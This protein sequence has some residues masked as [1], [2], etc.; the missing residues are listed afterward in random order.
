MAFLVAGDL[1][2]RLRADLT[3][4]DEALEASEKQLDKSSKKGEGALGMLTSKWAIMA[5]VATGAAYAMI[6]A[7]PSL[8]FAM[9][10]VAYRF[11]NMLAILGEEFAPLIEEVVL[12]ALD[13][14]LPVIK[15]LA[16]VIGEAVENIV[17]F[18]KTEE[19]QEFFGRTL[20]A[21]TEVATALW[22]LLEPAFQAVWDIL[23][24]V[25]PYLAATFLVTLEWVADAL[26]G[27]VGFVEWL[28]GALHEFAI[29]MNIEYG[30][31]WMLEFFAGLLKGGV[32][33]AIN[34]VW[35][36]INWLGDKFGWIA[37]I[38]KGVIGWIEEFWEKAEPLL[39]TPEGGYIDTGFVFNPG[40]TEGFLG[41]QSGGYVERSG[42][43]IVH[44]GE[45]ITPRG[46]GAPGGGRV[47]H[48]TINMGSPQI[49]SDYDVRRM[50]ETMS[51]ELQ[52]E[53]RRSIF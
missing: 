5:G 51:S 47:F 28:Q 31:I 6:R 38:I 41:F 44:R 34:W 9:E 1:V 37:D 26:G 32:T 10:E 17:A 8:G 12:P 27:V 52:T 4:L 24:L 43:A 15:E 22:D 33:E 40:A 23:Q 7:S 14:F 53:L 46:R 11:E 29:A 21:L 20:T 35:D 13:S 19:V 36:K 30:P 49:G 2:W 50:V 3:G 16:P 48:I 45:Q 42:L 25:T 18:L 39:A